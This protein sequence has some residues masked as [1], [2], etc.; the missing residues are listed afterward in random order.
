VP[1][2]FQSVGRVIFHGGPFV[3]RR[4]FLCVMAKANHTA[5]FTSLVGY[6]NIYIPDY[7]M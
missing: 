2:V 3:L 4:N 6:G 7:R 5:V 1:E